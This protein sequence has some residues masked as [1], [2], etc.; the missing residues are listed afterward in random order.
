MCVCVYAWVCVCVRV[1]VCWEWASHGSE[2]AKNHFDIIQ[3]SQQPT[4]ILTRYLHSNTL[5]TRVPKH[6]TQIRSRKKSFR[7]P[8]NIPTPY[9]H[10]NTLPICVS[11]HSQGHTRIRSSAQSFRHPKN[12]L[13]P[14][15]YSNTFPTCVSKY[16]QGHTRIRSSKKAPEYPDSLQIFQHPTYI[17]KP[18]PPVP[19]IT[20]RAT[21]RSEE[22]K[23]CQN[24]LTP[25]IHSETLPTFRHPTHLHPDILPTF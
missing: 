8:T 15:I 3:T 25:F 5:P 2:A 11:K 9:I 6:H 17:P 4:S 21:N 18:Y 23:K 24:I 13:T 19:L 22:A 10:S 12:I 7:Y 1:R 20:A 14:Y 16:S